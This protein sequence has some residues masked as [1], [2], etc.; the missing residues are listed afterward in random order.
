MS[1]Q[2][3]NTE[4]RQKETFKPI[5]DNEVGIYV[6]GVT[7]YDYCHIG[8]AR[9]MVVFDTV[10][11]H[12][13]ALG[14]NVTYVRNITDIDDKIIKR[15]L[16][17]GESIQSLTGRFIDAMHEDEAAMNVLRPDIEPLATEHMQDI[18]SMISTLIEKGHAYPAENGDV[19]FNVKSDEDYGR[20]SGKNIDD[21]E[22][23]A[24]V[25][26]NE[27]K[28][29]PLDFVLWKAS[30]ENEPAWSSPWGEG[31]PGWHIECSAMSTKCLGN[32]FDIHGGGMDLSFPHHENEIAQSECATG[33]HYVN[34]WMHCGFVR[35]DDEKMSKS[36]GNFFTIREVLKLYHPEVIR[37][38]LLA[39]HYRSPV[40]YSEDNLE[41]AKSSVSRLY[42]ALESFTPEQLTAAEEGTN[43]EVEFNDAMNDDFNTPQAMAVLFELAKEVNKTKSETLGG[44]L[45]KLANQI[46]LLEQDAT[47]FFK[48]QPS[49]S[50]LTDDAIQS[51]IDERAEARKN[52][53]FARSDQIRDE[54]LAQ[55][56]ELLDS[57]QGTTW[58]K[59]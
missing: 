25:E 40:N 51:L 54:L 56:I 29:D 59:V 5:H 48:S 39:S 8:H 49:Q 47:V 17:N 6:C 34:T 55:G 33:E 9:V 32:H 14:Y 23:G 10:V 3:Y 35:V 26:V 19:Y 36:L 46:G 45:K 7:V 43:Y 22:S 2:I 4:T 30:K 57:P 27:V 20:L 24:R 44:L 31:R 41:V 58:R 38:F 18:E 16:E 37:Y 50:D 13:R 52:K 11:R 12:L 28:K 15:A 1:L 53:D 21:L 42:S